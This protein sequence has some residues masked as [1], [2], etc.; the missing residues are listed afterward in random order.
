MQEGI[1]RDHNSYYGGGGR[2]AADDSDQLEK[3]RGPSFARA[4][5]T[6]PA[7]HPPQKRERGRIRE[8]NYV[9]RR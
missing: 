6:I 1:H 7:R 4:V 3:E 8:R 2:E 9:R 5:G